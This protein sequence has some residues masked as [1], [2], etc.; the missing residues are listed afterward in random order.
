M[1]KELWLAYVC[2]CKVMGRK[3]LKKDSGRHV[4]EVEE[5]K[6]LIYKGSW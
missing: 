1:K 4:S 6:Q 5:K 3:L 2:M